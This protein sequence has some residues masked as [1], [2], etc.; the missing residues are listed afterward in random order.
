MNRIELALGCFGLVL[1]VVGLIAVLRPDGLRRY[2]HRAPP[3]KRSTAELGGIVF[4]VAAVLFLLVLLANQPL[5]HWLLALAAICLAVLG[6][7]WR[8]QTPF[9]RLLEKGVARQS[10]TGLRI[11]GGILVLIALYWWKLTFFCC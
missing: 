7:M 5:S 10:E 9:Q 1:A 4:Y 11:I 6:S 8:R 2:A 3:L